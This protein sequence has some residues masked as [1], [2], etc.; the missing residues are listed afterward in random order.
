[1]ETIAS[2]FHSSNL[3]PYPIRLLGKYQVPI[4]HAT[5]TLNPNSNRRP[6]CFFIRLLSSASRPFS[7]SRRL[8]S[9]LGLGLGLGLELGLGLGRTQNLIPIKMLTLQLTALLISLQPPL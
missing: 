8:Y 9:Q 6:L 4:K 3:N 2:L 1:M 7:T 5:L